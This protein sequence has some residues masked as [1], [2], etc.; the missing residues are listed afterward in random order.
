MIWVWY[1][2]YFIIIDPLLI[3]R[4]NTVCLASKKNYCVNEEILSIPGVN[5]DDVC[6]NEVD[7]EDLIVDVDSNKARITRK[8]L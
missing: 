8:Y 7:I 6:G 3:R 5:I 4:L 2:D 1:T